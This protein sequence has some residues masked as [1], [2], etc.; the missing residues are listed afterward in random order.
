MARLPHGE[1]IRRYLYSFWRNSRTWQTDRRTDRHR[2]TAIAALCIA[3]HGNKS[4]SM[5]I[6]ILS[7][8]YSCTRNA[9]R[10]SVRRCMTF[11]D[12]CQLNEDMSG[13]ANERHEQKNSITYR[14]R[15]DRRRW[16]VL[17]ISA[18]QSVYSVRVVWLAHVDTLAM[19][20]L[21]WSRHV[22]VLQGTAALHPK[23]RPLWPQIKLIVGNDSD[24]VLWPPEMTT[25]NVSR[26]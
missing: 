26:P 17:N 14:R 21:C 2:V 24:A 22:T 15:R 8:E 19:G 20:E 7:V 9:H 10:E 11:S 23:V 18:Q 5:N 16:S 13:P 4:R 6:V 3:S 12:L 25:P 1:K